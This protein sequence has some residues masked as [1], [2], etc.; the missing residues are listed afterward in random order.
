MR[1]RSRSRIFFSFGNTFPENHKNCPTFAVR[2][3]T[4]ECLILKD[5][6]WE[7]LTTTKKK[8][9]NMLSTSSW[10]HTLIIL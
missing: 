3:E 10:T 9:K 5:R 8:S 7:Y 6:S 4:R 2:P 1:E